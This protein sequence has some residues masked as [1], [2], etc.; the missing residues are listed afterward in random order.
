[1]ARSEVV[2]DADRLRT[3]LS[4]MADDR[5]RDL[6][7]T[8]E[9]GDRR[10]VRLQRLEDNLLQSARKRG[11]PRLPCYEI[12]SRSGP[13]LRELFLNVE[14]L[15]Q[16]EKDRRSAEEQAKRE[17]LSRQFTLKEVKDLS[18]RERTLIDVILNGQIS[19][20]QERLDVLRLI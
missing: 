4:E 16:E 1:M 2:L 8:F 9:S 12:P 19:N 5:F 6:I 17:E 18:E 15:V 3:E 7:R 13:K 14:K 10:E 11:N 20:S